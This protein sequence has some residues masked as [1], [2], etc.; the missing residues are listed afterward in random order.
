MKKIIRNALI[1]GVMIISVMA[2]AACGG[3]NTAE[4]KY[5]F[6]DYAK[7]NVAYSDANGGN[8][9]KAGSYWRM[10]VKKDMDVDIAFSVDIDDMYSSCVLTVN[11]EK[12]LRDQPDIFNVVYKK[13]SLKKGDKLEFHAFF[14]NGIKAA[15]KPDGFN[16][17][18]FTI[19]LDGTNYAVDDIK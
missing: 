16:I 10:T 8:L 4:A 7:E 3:T 9:D 2:L 19:S 1:V 5:W 11:G 14:V 18:M 15:E 12:V 6:D 13:L 17:A